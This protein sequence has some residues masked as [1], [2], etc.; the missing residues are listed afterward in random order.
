MF[1]AA[2]LL[3]NLAE[4][5]RQSGRRHVSLASSLG[6][7]SRFAVFRGCGRRCIP[8]R[9]SVSLCDTISG[10]SSH[11]RI[12]FMSPRDEPDSGDNNDDGDDDGT[13]T[14]SH[15]TTST[16]TSSTTSTSTTTSSTTSTST[17]TTSTSQSSSSS[18]STTTTSG[19]LTSFSSSYT[20]FSSSSQNNG[21]ST[22]SQGLSTG[23]RTGLAFGISEL[24][25][26]EPFPKIL[27]QCFQCFS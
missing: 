3:L 1:V 18:S 8:A 7:R 13:S 6:L 24:A 4:Y 16:T 17:I 22:T 14:T 21:S 23:T 25:L 15:T 19:T 5:H 2:R 10:F 27:T 11:P 20:S 26:S 12:R 9:T